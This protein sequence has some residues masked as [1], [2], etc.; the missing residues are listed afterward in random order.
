MFAI[1]YLSALLTNLIYFIYPYRTTVASTIEIPENY[2]L[3]DQPDKIKIDNS[4]GTVILNYK[5]VDNKIILEGEYAFKQGVY[6]PNQYE[7]VKFYM[8]NIVKI[9]NTPVVLQKKDAVNQ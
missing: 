4:T 7:K 9:F 6:A 8:K 1:C 5:Q 2:V 3:V